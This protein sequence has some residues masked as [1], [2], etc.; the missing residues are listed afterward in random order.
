VDLIPYI[1]VFIAGLVYLAAGLRLVRLSGRTGQSAERLLGTSFLLW[2]TAYFLYEASYLLLG[3]SRAAPFLFS[4]LIADALGTLAFAAFTRRV[5]RSDERWARWLVVATAVGLVVGLGAA[6]W[7]GRW[8]GLYTI[9]NPWF[10]PGWLASTVPLGW[11][12]AEGILQ[13][14][15]A[16]R[17]QRLGLCDAATCHRFLLWSIAGVIWSLLQFVVIFQYLEYDTTLR[18]G[19]ALGTIV[20]CLEIAPVVAVWLVFYPPAFYRDWI[21]RGEAAST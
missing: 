18:W 5:F 11:M 2:G 20:G 4:A 3:E 12:A 19:F 21:R 13:H 16:R 1:Q 15:G 7:L 8:E 9:T 6:A 14:R 17:R 10:W